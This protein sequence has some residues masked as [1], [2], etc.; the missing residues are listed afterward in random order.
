[1]ELLKKVQ[2]GEKIRPKG[3]ILFVLGG[4]DS[5]YGYTVKKDFLVITKTM[6]CD[7][8]GRNTYPIAAENGVLNSAYTLSPI[9]L[10]ETITT[11]K[12]KA[13]LG[14]RTIAGAVLGGGVGAASAVNTNL[15]GGVTKTA[16]YNSSAH[17]MNINGIGA[18]VYYLYISEEV[19]YP[20]YY[21]ELKDSYCEKRNGYLQ[22][23]FDKMSKRCSEE[24]I[25]E[26]IKF[27]NDKILEF[28]KSN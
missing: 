19:G 24:M 11:G 10:K 15:N 18:T 17:A 14:G 3:D 20:P 16:T 9:P 27:M 7:I 8:R 2:M 13:S 21:S 25:N 5:S 22:I 26:I 12:K 28:N 4:Y 1:M 6:I 23:S